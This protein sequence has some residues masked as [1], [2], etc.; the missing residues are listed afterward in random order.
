MQDAES[1]IKQL[2]Q[3]LENSTQSI[4]TAQTQATQSEQ[5]LERVSKA[6]RE[7]HDVS[8]QLGERLQH[9]QSYRDE[10]LG[11]SVESVK[12]IRSKTARRSDTG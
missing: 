3:Q 6:E 12:R 2:H 9:L 10:Q 4:Q 1:L 8:S 11:D 5:I 7:M